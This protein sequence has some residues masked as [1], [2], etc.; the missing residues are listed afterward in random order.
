MSGDSIRERS[1]KQP[2]EPFEIHMSSGEVY[3]VRHQEQGFVTGANV[4]GW[5]TETDHVAM[6]SLLHITGIEAT[7][8]RP[9]KKGGKQ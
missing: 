8:S 2:F 4:Y 7:E 9:K 6:C 1:R 5:Y 3:Q